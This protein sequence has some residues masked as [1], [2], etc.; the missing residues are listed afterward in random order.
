M[1]QEAIEKGLDK[2]PETAQQL[3]LAKQTVLSGAFVQDY[4]KSHLVNEKD[5]RMRQDIVKSV[6]ADMR[7]KA[8]IEFSKD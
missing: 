7:S 5:L 4:V 6:I 3:E 2:Q 8:K 1:S